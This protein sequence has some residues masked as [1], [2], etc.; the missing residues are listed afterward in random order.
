MDQLQFVD[1]H[2]HLWDLSHPELTWS[3]LAPDAIHPQLGEIRQL[4]AGN[5]EIDNYLADV[6]N[7]NVIKAVH[8][9]AAIGSADPVKETEWLQGLADRSGFPHGIVGYS[10]LKDHGVEAELERHC[11]FAN[12]RGIRDF[13]EGDFLVDPSFQRGFALLEKFNLVCDLDCLWPDMA[14]AR[15]LAQKFPGITVVLDHAGFPQE[16]N[17]AY[18]ENWRAGMKALAEADNVVCKISGLGM[19]DQMA[20]GNWTVDSIRPYVLGCIEA[21]GVERSFFG[22]NWPVDKMYSDYATLVD[23]YAEI[24]K[25]FSLDEQTA[26]FS[27]NAERVYRL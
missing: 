25:D 18:L 6:K 1:S 13:S 27:G 17:D 5:Y 16:R 9:Q 12:A 20:G 8:V 21:Y 26:L 7:S 4:K 3:W 15:D 2:F 23:A 24:I 19:G 22:T 10:N 14:K 11:A